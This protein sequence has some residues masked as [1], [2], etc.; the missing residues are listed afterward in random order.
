MELVEKMSK[1]ME[2]LLRALVEGFRRE[3]SATELRDYV[4]IKEG[5]SFNRPITDLVNLGFV[6]TRKEGR[7]RLYEATPKG[8]LQC[9][10]MSP[11]SPGGQGTHS[12]TPPPPFTG[13]GVGGIPT[14]GATEPSSTSGPKATRS[15]VDRDKP[16]PVC[17]QPFED[18]SDNEECSDQH[19]EE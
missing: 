10:R 7:S 14:P 6:A 9:L 13:G 1:I 3:V 5:G 2:E 12:S 8:H 16:C 11:T 4:K 15:Q 18:P 19:Y 17:G